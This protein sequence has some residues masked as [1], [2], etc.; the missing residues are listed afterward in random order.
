MEKLLREPDRTTTTRGEMIQRWGLVSASICGL[1]LATYYMNV[2]DVRTM[3]NRTLEYI[4]PDLRFPVILIVVF[5][6]CGIFG[7]LVY[8]PLAK[9]ANYLV[10]REQGL[11]TGNNKDIIMLILIVPLILA[12]YF[13]VSGKAECAAPLAAVAV[14]LYLLFYFEAITYDEFSFTNLIDNLPRVYKGWLAYIFIADSPISLA[15]ITVLTLKINEDWSKN[16]HLK[17]FAAK[18]DSYPQS[19]KLPGLQ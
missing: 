18:L 2:L 16:E 8:R 6:S 12:I 4:G 17:G 10:P 1:F 3:V 9:L 14:P 15:Q 19:N 13:I 11:R 7:V 5:L